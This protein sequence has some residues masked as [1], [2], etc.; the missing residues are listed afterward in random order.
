MTDH[1]SPAQ[2][3]RDVLTFGETMLRLT[4]PGR[5]RLAQSP[6]LETWVA[7]SE[8]NVAAALCALGLSATWV[9]RLPDNSIGRRI[10]SQ[11][12]GC[13]IDVSRIVWAEPSERVGLFYAEPAAPPRLAQVLYDRAGSAASF[14]SPA[15]LPPLLFR[16][17]RHL[18]VTG[19]TPALSSHCAEAVLSAIGQAHDH[20]VTVSLDVNYRAKLWSAEAARDALLALAGGIDILFCSQGDAARVFGET[21]DS[22]QR[23]EGL[24]ERFGARI[25]AMTA[26]ANGAVGVSDEGVI[27]LPAIPLA[28]SVDRFG[29]GDAFAAGILAGFLSGQDLQASLHLGV[30]AA[31]VK[32]TIFGDMLIATR[33]EI[34]ALLAEQADGNW[35]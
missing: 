3:R 12:R 19:I 35:R 28:E 2:D 24:R 17:H 20:G 15:D 32:R 5:L 14:L 9:S 25:V 18:H 13:G 10:E 27:S 1:P 16:T 23:V 30:A 4:P 29:S 21:G 7:G 22:R 34:D 33:A 26:G 8:S 6:T 31:T 11:L